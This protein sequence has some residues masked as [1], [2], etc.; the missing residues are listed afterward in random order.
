LDFRWIMVCLASLHAVASSGFGFVGLIHSGD[1]FLAAS[2]VLRAST[3][4]AGCGIVAAAYRSC[5][6]LFPTQQVSCIAAVESSYLV[7]G[8]LGPSLTIVPLPNEY[9]FVIMGVVVLVVAVIL[10]FSS[11]G[12][13]SGACYRCCVVCRHCGL[14][15]FHH[16]QAAQIRRAEEDFAT[17]FVQRNYARVIL[18]SFVLGMNLVCVCAVDSVLALHLNQLHFSRTQICLC[19]SMFGLHEL[20][21]TLLNGALSVE[22][23][24]KYVKHFG[25]FALFA[26][27][28]LLGFDI[29]GGTARFYLAVSLI[30]AGA[31]SI[32]LI[33]LEQLNDLD[34]EAHFTPGLI[35]ALFG[36]GS[37]VGCLGGGLIV[38]RAS[39]QDLAKGLVMICVAMAAATYIGGCL[40]QRHLR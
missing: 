21:S 14:T 26:G 15:Y 5:P 38:Q 12:C 25:L 16:T 30:G 24:A 31:G 8:A 32:T 6:M 23:R 19:F 34:Q 4:F 7:G 17:R 11:G 29:F 39:F 3:G 27:L 37:A 36:L 35:N 18:T 2:V 20:G 22:V 28:L 33:S 9:V 40:L 13:N 1:A 10:F